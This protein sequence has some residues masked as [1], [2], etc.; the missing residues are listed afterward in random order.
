MSTGLLTRF[1]EKRQE[2][3]DLPTRENVLIAIA[4][5]CVLMLFLLGT[6]ANFRIQAGTRVAEE[7]RTMSAFPHLRLTESSLKQFPSGFDSFFNDRF[8]LRTK[9]VYAISFIKYKAFDLSSKDKVL[10]GKDGWLFFMDGGDEETLRRCPQMTEAE[11]AAWGK[12]LEQRR[13][14]CNRHGIKFFYAIAPTKSTIY[15]EFVPDQYTALYQKSRADQLTEY[16]R[17]HTKLDVIDIRPAMKAEKHRGLL[18][19]K[20]DTHWNRLGAYFGYCSLMDG[21]R[22]KFANVQPL[23]LSDMQFFPNI[24]MYCDLPDFAGLHGAVVDSFDEIRPRRGQGW[25]VSQQPPPPHDINDQTQRFTPFAT[26]SDKSAPLKAFFIRDSYWIFAQ[27]FISETFRRAYFYWDACYGFPA[28]RIL[29]EKPD[30][31]V[32][33]MVERS[34][35]R[36]VPPNPPELK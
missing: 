10:V 5:P 3:L 19:F 29:K 20:T 30:F 27:P 16:L 6:L 24:P 13:Q 32:M 33:E 18:Y 23:K 12:M 34:I 1:T 25:R 9:L 11:L 21:L 35:A 36:P 7:N 22:Q 26:E 31:V 8:L 28:E 14:W 17:D 4:F 2:S 15:R